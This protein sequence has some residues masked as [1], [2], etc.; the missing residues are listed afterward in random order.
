MPVANGTNGRFG[1]RNLPPFIFALREGKK[2]KKKRPWRNV[3]RFVA[4]SVWRV[5]MEPSVSNV[6]S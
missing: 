3:D 6:N 5:A 2:E 1:Q 4:P